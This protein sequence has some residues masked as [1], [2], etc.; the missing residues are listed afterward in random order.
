MLPEPFYLSHVVKLLRA[1]WMDVLHLLLD[2]AAQGKAVL[3]SP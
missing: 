1:E 2:A 3:T